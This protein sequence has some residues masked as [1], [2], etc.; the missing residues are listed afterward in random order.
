MFLLLA[1]LYGGGMWGGR[2]TVPH[3]THRAYIGSSQVQYNLVGPVLK[4][5]DVAT[6]VFCLMR[7]RLKRERRE[8]IK[9]FF[10]SGVHL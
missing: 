6:N 10:G 8:E 3:L 2:R 4:P 1:A 9:K 5:F 7:F